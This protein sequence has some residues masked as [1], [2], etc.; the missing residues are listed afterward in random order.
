[1]SGRPAANV[2]APLVGPTGLV[3]YALGYRRKQGAKRD[4]A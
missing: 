1:M 3:F 2:L 4:A